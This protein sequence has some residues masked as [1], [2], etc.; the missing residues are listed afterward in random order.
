MIRYLAIVV[1]AMCTAGCLD[2]DPNPYANG[3]D[4]G[5][6]ADSGSVV[7]SNGQCSPQSK[8]PASLLFENRSGASTYN[9]Y[10]VNYGCVEVYYLTVAPGQ[11][12]EQSTFVGHVW[13]ARDASSSALDREVVTP[14][15][16]L[17]TTVLL[18]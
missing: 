3:G 6:A 2:G 10:W 4:G 7:G 1:G 14:S 18:P 12:M 17:P 13:R 15:A 8:E 16:K 11:S 9:I 5:V